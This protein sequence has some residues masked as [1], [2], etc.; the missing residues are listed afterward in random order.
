VAAFLGVDPHTVAKGRIEIL[1]E[2]IDPTRV[3]KSGGGRKAAEKKLHDQG[4]DRGDPP[5]L[6]P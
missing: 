1:G 5:R 6:Q 4:K 2:D 3:R